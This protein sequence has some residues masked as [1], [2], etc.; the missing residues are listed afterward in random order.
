VCIFA[1]RQRQRAERTEKEENFSIFGRVNLLLAAA[2]H[3]N[4]HS[5]KIDESENIASREILIEALGRLFRLF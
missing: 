4:F 3:E 5:I 1:F 2:L